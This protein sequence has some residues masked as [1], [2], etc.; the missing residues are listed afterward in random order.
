MHGSFYTCLP[1]SFFESV[2]IHSNYWGVRC[3]LWLFSSLLAFFVIY[4]EEY[5][6]AKS[7]ETPPNVIKTQVI[8]A[9]I[10]AGRVTKSPV[11][12]R[13]C[14]SATQA[15]VIHTTS[16][17]QALGQ[18]GRSKKRAGDKRNPARRSPAFQSFTM[19]ESLEQANTQQ[20]KV[21]RFYYFFPYF[22]LFRTIV[23]FPY[24]LL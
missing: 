3:I 24:K 23:I 9:C 22:V 13:F 6:E 17:F 7:S 14:L 21:S 12:R 8:L 2:L 16:L 11:Y 20:E 1:Q 10:A 15:K 5:R 19:T 18:W 4:E